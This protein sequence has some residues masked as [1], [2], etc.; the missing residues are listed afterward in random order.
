MATTQKPTRTPMGIAGDKGYTEEHPA[1]AIIAASRVSSVPG[2]VLFGSDVRHQ[3]YMTIKIR[4]ARVDRHLSN[5]WYHGHGQQYIEVALTFAQ[6]VDFISTPNMGEGVACTV[7]WTREDGNLPYI[8][9]TETKTDE[10]NAEMRQRL[11]ESLTAMEEALA[12]AKTKAQRAPIEHAIRQLKDGAPFV[13]KQFEEHVEEKLAKARVEAEAYVSTMI[14]RAGI[15][16][17]G[18]DPVPAIER[19][20]APLEI[21]G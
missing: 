15:K 11:T 14:H 2:A 7:Q 17:L 12:Q 13:A 10:Y 1:Y 9:L 3:H 19:D 5:D 18:G 21:E 4:K 20:A 6:W 16:S 8:T